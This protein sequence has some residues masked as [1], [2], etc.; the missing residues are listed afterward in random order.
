MPNLAKSCQ[1]TPPEDSQSEPGAIGAKV[2]DTKREK[3]KR[4]GPNDS[5]LN[6]GEPN[7]ESK[8]VCAKIALLPLLRNKAPG[9][10][11]NQGVIPLARAG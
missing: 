8:V 7:P 11:R 6:P 1:T 5:E 10:N 4:G 3:A 2:G 9:L